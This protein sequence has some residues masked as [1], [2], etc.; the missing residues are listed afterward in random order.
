MIYWQ[1]VLHFIPEHSPPLDICIFYG[2][3]IFQLFQGL[4][5]K[6]WKDYSAAP[7]DDLEGYIYTYA[8]ISQFK[9]FIR[10]LYIDILH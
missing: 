3:L 2:V 7:T 8:N 6:T 10:L 1:T 4:N 9:A 5:N